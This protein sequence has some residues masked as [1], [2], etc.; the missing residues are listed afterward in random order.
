[1]KALG[2]LLCL[3]KSCNHYKQLLFGTHFSKEYSRPSRCKDYNPSSG[4]IFVIFKNV[5]ISK[6]SSMIVSNVFKNQEQFYLYSLKSICYSFK[7]WQQGLPLFRVPALIGHLMH[8]IMVSMFYLII[9]NHQSCMHNFCEHLH[10]F[11]AL[12]L[13]LLITNDH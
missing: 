13:F 2:F 11:I 7:P 3:V 5:N 8:V 6:T 12:L 4:I 1:M 9:C 10:L